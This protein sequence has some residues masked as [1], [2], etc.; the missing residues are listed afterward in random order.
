MKNFLLLSQLLW[1]SFCNHPVNR[2]EP[3]PTSE[4]GPAKPLD[5]HDEGAATKHEDSLLQFLTLSFVDKGWLGAGEH[6]RIDSFDKK[7]NAF[8]IS[9]W[10]KRPGAEH[11]VTTY[12]YPVY[13][14]VIFDTQKDRREMMFTVEEIPIELRWFSDSAVLKRV[15][16]ALQKHKKLM[17]DQVLKIERYDTAAMKYF[18]T[19]RASGGSK[20]PAVGRWCYD[21][22]KEQLEGG[23]GSEKLG[24]DE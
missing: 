3:A 23:T 24:I 14:D 5:S 7:G 17:R 20:N 19:Q 4:R 9:Q 13:Q 6:L 11:L 2:S 16:T 10:K 22:K 12:Q 21:L 18:L 15:S 1:L 8:Y